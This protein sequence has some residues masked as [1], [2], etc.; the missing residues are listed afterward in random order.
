[1]DPSGVFF[2][3]LQPLFKVSAQEQFLR[4]LTDE[5]IREIGKRR[6]G[7]DTDTQVTFRAEKY[8]SKF[9]SLYRD[10]VKRERWTLVAEDFKLHLRKT[11]NFRLP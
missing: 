9:L 3:F 1:M 6:P 5:E 4:T 7:G 8:I 10:K 11:S 2:P